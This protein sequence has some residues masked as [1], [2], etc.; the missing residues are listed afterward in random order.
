MKLLLFVIT[1]VVLSAIVSGSYIES[2][3]WPKPSVFTKGDKVV[4]VS[5][6][7]FKTLGINSAIPKT[8]SEAY[9]RYNS[10]IFNHKAKEGDSISRIATVNVAVDDYSETYPQ[11]ETDESYTLDIPSDA[12]GE[13]YMT[14]KVK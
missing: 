6:F 5:S 13:I 12:T 11:L 1:L 14:A 8:L 3:I 9:S 4:Q 7:N 2:S 10:L